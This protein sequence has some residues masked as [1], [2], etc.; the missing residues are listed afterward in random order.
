MDHRI[1]SDVEL[2]KFRTHKF[3]DV[4]GTATSLGLPILGWQRSEAP[5]R[6]SFFAKLCPCTSGTVYVR[7]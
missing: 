7:C 6:L 1:P 2:L 4:S 5:E 3:T